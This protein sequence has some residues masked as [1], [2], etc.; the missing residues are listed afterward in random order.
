MLQAAAT[1]AAEL[2]TTHADA[3]A[4]RFPPGHSANINAYL[5]LLPSEIAQLT[6]LRTAIYTPPPR[7]HLRLVS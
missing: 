1:I 3:L 5:H 2:R 6:A 4:K 7:R